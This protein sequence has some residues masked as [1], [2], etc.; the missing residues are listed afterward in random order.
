METNA[1]R[2]RKSALFFSKAAL[3]LALFAVFSVI[4]WYFYPEATYWGPGN[5]LVLL[6][7]LVV[8]VAFSSLYGALR[9]GVLRLGEVVYSYILTLLVT[10][11]LSYTMFA[12]IARSLINPAMLIVAT[13]IQFMIASL[14][15]YYINRLYFRLYPAREV[16]VVYSQRALAL[17]I[18]G[19][20][21]RIKDRYRV[22]VAISEDE[23]YEQII[24]SISGYASVMFCDIDA[25]LRYRLFSYSSLNGK[26]VYVV[27]SFQDVL[28]RSSHL[29]QLF[30]TPV[31]YSKNNGLST[32]QAL[33]KRIMD[34]VISAV[35]LIVAS[36]FM[37][38]VAAA[39]KLYDWGPVIFAQ[40][41]LTLDG[42][43][44]RLYKFRSMIIDAEKDGGPRL[45]SV[46][47]DRITPIGRIIRKIRFD[48]LPQF[49]N[50]LKG[51]M[52]VV[53]PRP[54]RPE[55]ALQYQ[56]TLPEFALRLRVKAGLTG[57]AQIYGRYNTTMR[58]KLLL[59]LLY[60]E[61]HSVLMDFRMLFMTVKILFM[62]ESTEGIAD[63]AFLP[64]G[65]SYTD[66][67]ESAQSNE[68]RPDSFDEGEA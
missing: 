15:A 62:P 27:P 32:E 55:I 23:G 36:P 64:G 4:W 63:G 3:T 67:P 29:T 12:L 51:D 31:F 54:E 46:N 16:A 42:R 2:F 9:I 52:S 53:G 14:A 57:Y 56:K 65:D 20:M 25:S 1:R 47:D 49:F 43:I 45:S 11:A 68:E 28:V 66:S 35:A 34:I 6:F 5:L 37:L 22:C 19:K 40:E 18:I 50:I 58:D 7:Y 59:D 8:L 60:T 30:D 26:R 24:R 21:S 17:D 10:N 39:I 44:F 41:R 13:G 38:V 33:F 61:N 48:E